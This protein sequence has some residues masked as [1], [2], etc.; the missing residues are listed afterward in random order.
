M[1][2]PFW[3]LKPWWCQPWTILLTGTVAITT[4]WLVLHIWWL[5]AAVAVLVLAWWCLF[6]L[7][8]PNI[9]PVEQ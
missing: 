4:T 1:A 8:V 6:L 5:T 7:I 3:S 9:T 2:H